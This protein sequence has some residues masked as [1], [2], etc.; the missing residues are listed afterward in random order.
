MGVTVRWLD[1]EQHILVYEF[2]EPWVASE[3]L[4]VFRQGYDMSRNN[5][6]FSIIF[7]LNRTKQVPSD[8]LMLYK[9]LLH[10]R[11]N[12]AHTRIFVGVKGM[13]HAFVQMADRLMPQLL[14]GVVVVDTFGEAL[15]LIAERMEVAG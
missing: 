7:D 6:G 9:P 12:N 8:I 15:A 5:P 13:V 14:E 11:Q 3:T 10:M 4:T 1:N 2:V